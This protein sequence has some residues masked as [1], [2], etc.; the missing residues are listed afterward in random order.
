MLRLKN[1]PPT[2]RGSRPATH[3]AALGPF[4]FA[5]WAVRHRSPALGLG[6]RADKGLG[7]QAG[8]LHRSVSGR[9]Q[10]R[11]SS[12]IDVG[13]AH[14]PMQNGLHHNPSKTLGRIHWGR[15]RREAT[16][17]PGQVTQ[18]RSRQGPHHPEGQPEQ[19]QAGTL[20]SP[21]HT[22]SLSATH[23]ATDQQACPR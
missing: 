17:K 8:R 4:R 6:F 12:H 14:T 22:R 11:R 21:S 2:N 16:R 7:F 3:D 23:G 13:T 20:S 9:G 1:P 10:L 19:A 18:E 15:A 5:A